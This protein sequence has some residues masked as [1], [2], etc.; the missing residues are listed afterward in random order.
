[1]NLKKKLQ[2][3]KMFAG[4]IGPLGGLVFETAVLRGAWVFFNLFMGTWTE[5][6]WKPLTKTKC[7]FQN[8][9]GPIPNK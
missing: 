9:F 5:K 6:G 3:F 7:H 1:M 4:H 2:N 8:A